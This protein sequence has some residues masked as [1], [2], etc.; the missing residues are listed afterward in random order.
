MPDYTRLDMAMAITPNDNDVVRI[1]IENLGD[2]T[3]YPHSHSNHQAS[4]GESQNMRISYS[5]RF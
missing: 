4:V 5:R 3:Y 1:N 2:E